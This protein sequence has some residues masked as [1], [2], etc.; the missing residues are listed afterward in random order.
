MYVQLR[1]RALCLT[2]MLMRSCISGLKDYTSSLSTNNILTDSSGHIGPTNMPELSTL[3][4]PS[5]PSSHK[6][7]TS[8]YINTSGITSSRIS[9]SVLLSPSQLWSSSL[10]Q[11]TL[12]HLDLI[13][14][15]PV[16]NSMLEPVTSSQINAPTSMCAVA[17]TDMVML[18]G[19]VP[20]VKFKNSG[21]KG[22]VKAMSAW[23]TT[24]LCQR[25]LVGGRASSGFLHISRYL[26]ACTS[27]AST[28]SLL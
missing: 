8:C 21:D 10:P 14:Q 19:T 22:K 20:V 16:R 5:G 13:Q 23:V 15:K 18:A 1:T 3:T 11:V 25:F 4:K 9:G 24:L 12:D 2:C 28:T 26:G 6:P 27:H 17:T 7:E